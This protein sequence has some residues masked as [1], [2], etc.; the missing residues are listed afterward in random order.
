MPDIWTIKQWLHKRHPNKGRKWLMK[1]YYRTRKGNKWTFHAKEKLN[2]GAI[3]YIDLYN[4]SWTNIVRHIKVKALANPY[5]PVWNEYFDNRKL[6]RFR[7]FPA[8]GSL[9]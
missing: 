5:N 9:P 6:K 7:T 4:A 8:K 2:N 3:N 1:N